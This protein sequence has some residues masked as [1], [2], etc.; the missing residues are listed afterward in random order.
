MKLHD[1]PPPGHDDHRQHTSQLGPI[2]WTMDP[3]ADPAERVEV[4]RSVYAVAQRSH[5]L[6]ASVSCRSRGNQP[7]DTATTTGRR[8]GGD[9]GAATGGIAKVHGRGA[10]RAVRRPHG[11]IMR[12]KEAVIRPSEIASRLVSR[13]SPTRC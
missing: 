8:A 4:C 1:N 5:S 3:F 10:K 9:A 11:E 2:R 13:R 12:L 7:L 6:T